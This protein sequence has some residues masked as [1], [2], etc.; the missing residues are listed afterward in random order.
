MEAFE[1][2]RLRFRSQYL[3]VPKE[4]ACPFNHVVKKLAGSYILYSHV[5]L[6]VTDY[7][8]GFMQLVLL[9]DIFDYDD[10]HKTNQEILSDISDNNLSLILPKLARYT[11]RF[12]LICVE[13][14]DIYLLHDATATRKVYYCKINDLVY[15]SSQPH[16][17]AKV[18]GLNPTS[19]PSKLEYYDS[20]RFIGLF[21][22]SIGTTTYYDEVQQLLPN[23]YFSV[24]GYNTIRFWPTE[25][26]QDIS[27][28]ECAEI[29]APMI[30]GYM[31]NICSRY[32][33]ML[34]VT[35]GK[36]TRTL[37]A[38]A[39]NIKDKLY[40]YTNKEEHMSA[41]YVDLQIP[42]KLLTKLGLEYHILNPYKLEIDEGFKKV[43]F[44]NNP[45]ASQF[46][47]PIIYNY[48]INFSDRVNL[49]GNIATSASWFFP[50]LK[51]N[52]SSKTL[53]DIYRV[54]QFQY[55]WETYSDWLKGIQESVNQTG[56]LIM[57]L[58]YW[59]ERLGNWGTQI[60]IDKDIAQNDINPFNSRMMV[61][62]IL[63]VEPVYKRNMG[64]Y[65][66]NSAII[67]RLWP[68][69]LD[70]PI[71]PCLRNKFYRGLEM[72][73]LLGVYYRMLYS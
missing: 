67:K 39:Y 28:E 7:S 32:E 69:C 31:E 54:N 71:N 59:E 35:A 11:G 61:E 21:N 48:Y 34:P 68:E 52:I 63:S 10:K 30:R 27:V 42:S 45:L 15:C 55:A 16:L 53:V 66:I 47:L 70:L 57:D 33:T 1:L 19:N 58:F 2:E 14:N 5:D 56:F 44:E 60:Q 50:N 49:P 36:D 72:F 41:D 26:R 4:I 62:T 65:P 18:L 37:L 13:K 46:F 12:V 29:C 73:G 6:L 24:S 17:L 22:A 43:Y 25:K 40:Y 20:K 3:L 64:T 38:A 9:G 23:H 8:N 51:K